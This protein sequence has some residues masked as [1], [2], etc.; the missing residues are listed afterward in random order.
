VA[1][2][3][4]VEQRRPAVWPARHVRR[5]RAGEVA[6]PTNMGENYRR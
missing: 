6:D 2:V 5:R 1:G 3:G 4:L